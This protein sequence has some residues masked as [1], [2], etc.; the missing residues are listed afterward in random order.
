MNGKGVL[1]ILLLVILSLGGWAVHQFSFSEKE[2]LGESIRPHLSGFSVLG[3]SGSEVF[4]SVAVE[5]VFL[6]GERYDFPVDS[7]ISSLNFDGKITLN[8]D[9]AYMRLIALDAGGREYLVFSTDPM[10]YKKGVYEFSDTC[11]ESC[12]FSS[13][14]RVNSIRFEGR[15]ASINLER[16]GYLDGRQISSITQPV[17]EIRHNQIGEIVDTLNERNR[18][19]G[20]NWTA[21]RTSVA[22]MT[23]S[24]RRGI[25]ASVDGEMPNMH[26]F[27][28]YT[29]G[30]FDLPASVRAELENMAWNDSVLAEPPQSF[31]GVADAEQ[32]IDGWPIPKKVA[33]TT[34]TWQTAHG[35]NWM[36]SVKNQGQC[37]S[38]WD[39][40]G[41]GTM[42]ARINVYFNRHL[43]VDLSEQILLS[44]YKVGGCGG[45][46]P[47]TVFDAA[48]SGVLGIVPESCL[49]YT[50]RDDT[51]CNL[52]AN[53]ENL[54]WRVN[55]STEDI[56]SYLGT[57]A[58]QQKLYEYGP[59]SI[60]YRSWNHAMVAVGYS[61]TAKTW[62]VKNS[63]GSG[64]GSGGYST[65]ADLPTNN[66]EFHF[67]EGPIIPPN[68]SI[69]V[70]CV[71]KD[72]DGY[73]NWGVGPMPGSC[74]PSCNQIF[75]DCDDSKKSI[76]INCTSCNFT[77][78]RCAEIGKECGV[79]QDPIC[80]KT[81]NCTSLVA[82]K[83]DDVCTSA[84][85]FLKAVSNCSDLQAI[86]KN[87]KGNYALTSD[88]DC[89][90]FDLKKNK[91]GFAPIGSN[92]SDKFEGV[93]D[94]D[95]YTIRNIFMNVS[96][97]KDVSTT[98]GGV[99]GIVSGG[100]IINV[101]VVNLTVIG[102][103]N[104]S[105]TSNEYLGGLV[106]SAY[107]RMVNLDE[108]SYYY[109]PSLISHVNISGRVVGGA[110]GLVGFARTAN[111]SNCNVDVEIIQYTNNTGGIVGTLEG[112]M[113]KCT[114]NGK[115]VLYS[116]I[117]HWPRYVG[118][119]AGRVYG[120]VYPVYPSRILDSYSQTDIFGSYLGG[121]I[122]RSEG[123]VEI[124][125]SSYRGILGFNSSVGGIPA[126]AEMEEGSRAGNKLICGFGLW[127]ALGR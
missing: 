100:S 55:G 45:G 87:P 105:V 28:Y 81:L 89:A 25:I 71:D 90:G 125:N 18:E 124:V 68:S 43:N 86:R 85:K 80:G 33:P 50:A 119:L 98:A 26:G 104:G 116:N 93:F 19:E 36:T 3:V 77:Y 27:E 106:G 8:D 108:I 14:A 31:R 95:G 117:S 112:N 123:S 74:S 4:P 1:I 41:I 127:L 82:P 48:I 53:W 76:T 39:F 66:R 84:G 10:F 91:M 59:M 72:G 7:E 126:R 5:R 9:L 11:E 63:W 47:T 78:A 61:K 67:V 65:V 2:S 34:F 37:G 94:G 12:K 57:N 40:S 114:F 30:V 38:C 70:S 99:F 35:E 60:T 103:F 92:W 101:T 107:Q 58:S 118:G 111:I 29:S 102:P 115:F 20:L 75:E 52:C 120:S 121:L 83:P 21:G 56:Q 73:C 97:P 32:T 88:I 46:Q 51:A 22:N 13:S 69:N 44:C 79:Y 49:P 64:W 109:K 54:S 62:T 16:F 110:G 122:G 42:E 24:Q 23:Y 6:G 17:E 15:N 96:D 113:E